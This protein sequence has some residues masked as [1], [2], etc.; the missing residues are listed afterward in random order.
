MCMQKNRAATVCKASC[1]L[2]VLPHCICAPVVVTEEEAAGGDAAEPT[3]DGDDEDA[4]SGSSEDD[5]ESAEGDEEDDEM[6]D[7]ADC[8]LPTLAQALPPLNCRGCRWYVARR[9]ALPLACAG[10][11][12][13]AADRQVHDV[14]AS[15]HTVW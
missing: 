3:F 8:S 14:H 9:A 1:Q 11:G 10:S 12:R 13:P 15:L 2:C 6:G 5:E 7:A 4:S